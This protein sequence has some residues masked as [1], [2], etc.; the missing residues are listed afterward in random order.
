[1]LEDND[2]ALEVFPIPGVWDE[3][4]ESLEDTKWNW[5]VVRDLCL[6]SDQQRILGDCCLL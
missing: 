4:S 5:C 3:H 1:M 6:F 2:A